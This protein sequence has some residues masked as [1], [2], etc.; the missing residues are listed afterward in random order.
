[1]VSLRRDGETRTARVHLLVLAEFVGACPDG[2][3]GRHKNGDASNPAL[4]NL[5]YGTRKQNVE[6]ARRHGTLA[7]G[8]RSGM[9]KLATAD[10]L[11]IYE[12]AG[13]KKQAEIAAQFGVA[14]SHVSII[15]AAKAWRHLGENAPRN[16]RRFKGGPPRK[17]SD[18]DIATIKRLAD[19][20]A[21]GCDLADKYGVSPTTICDI[22][23]YGVRPTATVR[24]AQ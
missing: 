3:E 7:I 4:S 2:Q 1:M 8:E 17:L 15:L 9:S 21:R 12:I 24:A 19:A 20:G 22:K 5:E 14:R 10:V 16:F 23:K 6:D 13:E 18:H 11:A